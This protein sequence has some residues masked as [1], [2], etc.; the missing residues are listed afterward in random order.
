MPSSEDLGSSNHRIIS[1]ARG[2]LLLKVLGCQSTIRLLA[3]PSIMSLLLQPKVE[4][5]SY[6]LNTVKDVNNAVAAAKRA[7]AT[8][9]FTDAQTRSNYLN[10]IADELEKR[11]P[12]LV[13][14]EVCTSHEDWLSYQTLD[15]G[16]SLEESGADL[17]DTVGCFRCAHS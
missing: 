17:D 14:L 16:K 13:E 11:K 6:D 5:C 12:Y 3:H 1:M 10:L 9:S 2:L 15:N 8:W 7:F 4:L